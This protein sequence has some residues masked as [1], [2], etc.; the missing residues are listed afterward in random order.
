VSQQGDD[1]WGVT[2][3][4]RELIA[5]QDLHRALEEDDLRGRQITTGLNTAKTRTS[6]GKNHVGTQRRSVTS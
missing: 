4:T 3:M 6:T 5:R 2:A 1:C